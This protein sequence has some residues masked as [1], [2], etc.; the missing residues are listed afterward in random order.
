MQGAGGCPEMAKGGRGARAWVESPEALSV[1]SA[2]G[3][4]PEG[5][6]R[7]ELQTGLDARW[8]HTWAWPRVGATPRVPAGLTALRGSESG[9]MRAPGFKAPLG[10]QDRVGR[11]PQ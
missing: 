4:R 10:P 5:E 11:G 9:V 1:A 2:P 3:G 6:T 8:R 7:R